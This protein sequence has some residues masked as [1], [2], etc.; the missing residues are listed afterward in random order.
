MAVSPEGCI[1]R[2]GDPS[3]LALVERCGN[4]GLRGRFVLRFRRILVNLWAMF[5]ALDSWTAHLPSG[6]YRGVTIVDVDSDG[7]FETII[8]NADG[9]NLVLKFA[10]DRLRD[11]ASPVL[12]DAKQATFAVAAADVNGD[13][14]EELYFISEASRMLRRGP[15]RLWEPWEV[16]GRLAT[17]FQV[18]DLRGNGRYGMAVFQT[19]G[20]MNVLETGPRGELTWQPGTHAFANLQLRPPVS[21][22]VDLDADGILDSFLAVPDAPHRLEVLVKNGLP[23]DRATPSLAMPSD[24][25]AAIV[26]DFDNDGFE[27]LLLVNTDEQNRLYLIAADVHL[28]ECGDAAEPGAGA[29]VADVDG[30]GLLELIVSRRGSIHVCKSRST[31][32]N[33]WLRVLPLTRFQAPARGAIVTCRVNGRTLVRKID[34]GTNGLCLNEPVAHFGLGRDPVV[35]SVSIRWPDGATLTFPDPDVNCTYRVPY[36]KG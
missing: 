15:D 4:L 6:D 2:V 13:G 27:E 1:G 31:A 10:K 34:G 32:G 24:L 18:H 11:V 35:E 25:S 36:P 22:P 17:G 14:V 26:A 7:I 20:Q 21:V 5:R 23:R 16:R 28:L 19:A 12:A 3:G 8:A 9:P 30:D 29:A 33:A